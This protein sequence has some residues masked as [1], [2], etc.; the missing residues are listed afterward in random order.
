VKKVVIVFL[1]ILPLATAFLS[2]EHSEEKP[3]GWICS[4]S[5]VGEKQFVAR[6]EIIDTGVVC[7]RNA[8]L[9]LYSCVDNDCASTSYRHDTYKI[10]G[11]L[12]RY[13]D[14]IVGETYFYECLVCKDPSINQRPILNIAQKEVIIDEGETV[15]LIAS[16]TDRE[17]DRTTLAYGGWMTAIQ[18]ETDYTDAGTHQVTLTCTD[19]FGAQTIGNIMIFVQDRNRPPEIIAVENE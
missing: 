15:T 9:I 10:N 2:L 18:K 11:Q 16:C 19:E 6:T 5:I 12:K 8:R 17:G 13:T 1:L 3:A 7:P 14:Y 4:E